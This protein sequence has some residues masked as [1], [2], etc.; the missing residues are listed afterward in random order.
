MAFCR[1]ITLFGPASVRERARLLLENQP[2]IKRVDALAA[3]QLRL[4][5]SEPIREEALVC[6]LSG[7][8]I[9]GFALA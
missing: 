7:S 2:Q 3:G 5:M 4:F 6:L 9:S 8:G 1:T